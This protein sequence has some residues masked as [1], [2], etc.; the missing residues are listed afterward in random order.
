MARLAVTEPVDNFLKTRD[1]NDEIEAGSPIAVFT[2]EKGSREVSMLETKLRAVRDETYDVSASALQTS[3]GGAVVSSK[4]EALSLVSQLRVAR[5]DGWDDG[6]STRKP[7]LAGVRLD[8]SH[9][10]S[11][12]TLGDFLFAEAK[13]AKFDQTTRLL[14]AFGSLSPDN[15]GISLDKR[16]GGKL[17]VKDILKENGNLNI[18][19]QVMKLHESLANSGTKTS[20][21]DM[22]RKFRSIY[23]TM[24]IGV[25]DQTLNPSDFSPYH[26][27]QAEVSL[28]FREGALSS[29]RQAVASI[30]K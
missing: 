12:T 19:T 15:N 14:Y 6:S 8:I 30:K 13:L 16:V 10:W 11:K 28:S 3:I 21:S 26:Q 2:L 18:V 17:T 29:L 7:K 23:E 22:N 20:Q 25:R 5:K 1:S 4:G 9:D 27:A 24:L